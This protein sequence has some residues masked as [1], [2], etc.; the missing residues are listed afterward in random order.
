MY[1]FL[2]SF[3]LINL[4]LFLWDRLLGIPDL[5]LALTL[6][7]FGPPASAS[8]VLVGGVYPHTHLYF[9]F[10]LKLVVWGGVSLE[11]R[12]GVRALVSGSRAL[13][14]EQYTLLTAMLPLQPHQTQFYVMLGLEPRT[15]YMLAKHSTHWVTSQLGKR[16]P[17]LLLFSKKKILV[18]LLC[19]LYFNKNL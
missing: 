15:L 17:V 10:F 6:N 3:I 4:L 19:S 14:G 8:E 13:L 12:E 5:D 7:F 18:S 9:Y 16:L 1:F 11:A 2:S